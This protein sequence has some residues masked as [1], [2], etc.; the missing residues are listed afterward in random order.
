MFMQNRLVHHL[1]STKVHCAPPKF[2]S[3]E[4]YSLCQK[5]RT[6]AQYAQSPSTRGTTKTEKNINC[7][8]LLTNDY[9]LWTLICMFVV[10]H[11]ITILDRK[12]KYSCLLLWCLLWCLF[13]C[14]LRG[15]VD[16]KQICLDLWTRR[17]CM[18]VWTRGTF[19][20]ALTWTCHP[21]NHLPVPHGRVAGQPSPK[22][23]AD[24]V[25]VSHA[26]RCVQTL[27]VQTLI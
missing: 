10:N 2:T 18:R 20:Q 25:G 22:I 23:V 14:N 9:T 17:F 12:K 5:K 19:S 16:F 1:I 21:Y 13:T 4:N 3:V 8:F 6:I 15:Q 26:N 11:Q 24:P 7:A 27:G